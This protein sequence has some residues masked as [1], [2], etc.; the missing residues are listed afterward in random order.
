MARAIKRL[1]KLRRSIEI[2]IVKAVFRISRIEQ[3]NII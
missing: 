3:K 2:L 1:L